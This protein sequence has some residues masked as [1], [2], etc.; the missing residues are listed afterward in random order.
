MKKGKIEV[1]LIGSTDASVQY[2]HALRQ[3]MD[4]FNGKLSANGED[5]R[6]VYAWFTERYNPE[7][8]VGIK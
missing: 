5:R 6:A 7:V 8:G 3:V 1:E 2:I 4:E